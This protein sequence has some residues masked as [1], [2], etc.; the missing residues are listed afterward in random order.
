[1]NKKTLPFYRSF[2]F[3]YFYL[4]VGVAG[5]RADGEAAL[6]ASPANSSRERPLWSGTLEFLGRQRS[7]R[8]LWEGLGAEF[9]A[10]SLEL[11]YVHWEEQT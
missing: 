6:F 9:G 1:M 11:H 3:L 7:R 10:L 5:G 8:V 2:S 4:C